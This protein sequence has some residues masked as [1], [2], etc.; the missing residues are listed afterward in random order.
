MSGDWLSTGFIIAVQLIDIY[1]SVC[2]SV[3]WQVIVCNS[4]GSRVRLCC[5]SVDCHVQL[6]IVVQ[7]IDKYECL[8]FSIYDIWLCQ[9]F[10]WLTSMSVCNS[11]YMVYDCVRGSVDWQVWVSAIQYIWYM[12][13][14]EVQLI[15]K[16]E[17]AIQYIWYMIVSDSEVQLIDRYDGVC[18]HGMYFYY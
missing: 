6:C 2:S 15:D 7:L 12:I 14:S 13:V 11:V 8:Q 5:S 3:N 1:N 4:V 16:Y 9:R 10:S 18:D 17:C